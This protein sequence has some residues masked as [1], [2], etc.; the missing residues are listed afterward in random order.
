MV[1]VALVDLAGVI[2]L[3]L[4]NVVLDDDVVAA[5]V[6]KAITVI[7]PATE[8]PTPGTSDLQQRPYHQARFVEQFP[9]DIRGL[10]S[11]VFSL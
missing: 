2:V 9:F 3:I 7:L 5:V 11:L 1:R 4:V 10:A 6:V 8:H